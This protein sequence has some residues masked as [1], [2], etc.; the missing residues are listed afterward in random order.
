M[1]WLAL[2]SK[3]NLLVAIT[4]HLMMNHVGDLTGVGLGPMQAAIGALAILLVVTGQLKQG[5]P[6]TEPL[7]GAAGA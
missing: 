5:A 1:T 3:G 4:A 2:R 7:A 6:G